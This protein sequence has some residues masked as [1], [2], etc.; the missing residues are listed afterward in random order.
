MENPTITPNDLK[1]GTRIKLRNGWLAT[2]EDNRKGNIRMATVEGFHTEMGSVY[3]HD[4]VAAEIEGIWRKVKLTDNMKKCRM[5][6]L[7]MGW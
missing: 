6:N 2:L 5:L 3:A 1:K 7:S 4:I